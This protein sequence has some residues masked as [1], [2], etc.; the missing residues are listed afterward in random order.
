MKYTSL[1]L[2]KQIMPTKVKRTLKISYE[3]ENLKNGQNDQIDKVKSKV[4]D[5][6]RG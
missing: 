3:K 2:E 5:L 4:G 1:F 6:S